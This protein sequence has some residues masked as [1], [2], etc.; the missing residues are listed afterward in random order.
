[1][2]LCLFKYSFSLCF[3]CGCS[4]C[5][6]CDTI[7]CITV[8]SAKGAALYVLLL[9]PVVDHVSGSV[10]SFVAPVRWQSFPRRTETSVLE[11]R[12]APGRGD[13]ENPRRWDMGL[14]TTI[15]KEWFIIGIVLVILLAKLEPS[16]GVK[17]GE[18][19]SLGLSALTLFF[20]S[21]FLTFYYYGRVIWQRTLQV[22][23]Q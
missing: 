6:P 10:Y 13:P 11:V 12:R 3:S 9:R 23:L 20:L 1:M 22:F 19:G 2:F 8:Y 14:L 7:S 18:R 4:S 17:G 16:I 15:R 21:V 5:L